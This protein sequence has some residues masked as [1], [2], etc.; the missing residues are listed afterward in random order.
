MDEDNKLEEVQDGE[1]V[2][3]VSHSIPSDGTND[4]TVLLNLE[5]L[6]KAHISSSQKIQ[7]EL[8]KHREMLE[9]SFENDP[10][11]KEHARLAKE[12]NKV[13]QTT[14]Q[15]IMKRPSVSA[16]AN[17]VKTLRAELKEKQDSLSD[18]LNEYRRMSGMDEIEGEDGQIRQI[19]YV[20]K[21]VRKG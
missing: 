5:Q 20:A 9:D 10:T 17:K 3:E 21:L 15:E 2:Q 6:I 4:A 16:I 18:Y 1:I 7:E 19:V 8:K 11:Y 14:R 13:K 12:A